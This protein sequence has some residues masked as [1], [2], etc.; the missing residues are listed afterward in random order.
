MPDTGTFSRASVGFDFQAN[1]LAVDQP[2]IESSMVSPLAFTTVPNLPSPFTDADVPWD[3]PTVLSTLKAFA[4]ANPHEVR[5]QDI[6]GIPGSTPIPGGL[7]Q[8]S[9]TLFDDG[10]R[11]IIQLQN[12]VHGPEQH[13]LRGTFAFFQQLLTSSHPL[14]IWA[15]T[16]LCFRWVAI[17]NPWG[18]ING[19]RDNA[20]GVNLNRNGRNGAAAALDPDKGAFPYSEPEAKNLKNWG[21]DDVARMRRTILGMDVHQ[22]NSPAATSGVPNIPYGFLTDSMTTSLQVQEMHRSA[23]NWINNLLAQRD[24]SGLT[25]LSPG[26]ASNQYLWERDSRL[27]PY[28]M[29]Y[30]VEKA[31]KREFDPLRT[32]PDAFCFQVEMPMGTSGNHGAM[33]TPPTAGWDQTLHGESQAVNGTVQLDLLTALVVTAQVALAPLKSGTHLAPACT[34]DQIQSPGYSFFAQSHWNGTENRP[35]SY[36]VKGTSLTVDY[37]GAP[38]DGQVVV[39]SYRGISVA[40]PTSITGAAA[41]SVA[42]GD[43]R[44]DFYCIMGGTAS[45]GGFMEFMQPAVP[46]P[47]GSSA[48][49]VYKP[50]TGNPPLP[51]LPVQTAEFALAYDASYLY[52]VCGYA[53]GAYTPNIYRIART[54]GYSLGQVYTNAVAPLLAT[55]VRIAAGAGSSASY[56]AGDT[57]FF[58]GGT[59]TYTVGAD[60]VIPSGGSALVTISPGLTVAQTGGEVV[61]LLP[62]RGTWSLWSTLATCTTG[63]QRHTAHV[64]NGA[65]YI[66]GGRDTVDYRATIIRKDLTTQAE[67]LFATVSTHAPK[68]GWHAAT[69]VGSDLY[70]AGGWGGSTARNNLTKVNLGTA[71]ITALTTIPTVVRQAKMVSDGNGSLWLATG[72]RSGDTDYTDSIYKYSIAGNSWTTYT[73]SSGWAWDSVGSDEEAA[74]ASPNL[75][76]SGANMVFNPV[77]GNILIV[78]G[79]D[80][81][82]AVLGEV[83]EFDPDVMTMYPRAASASLYGQIGKMTHFNVN[84]GQQISLVCVVSNE[85]D[86]TDLTV[87]PYFRPIWDIGP[88]G[89][90]RQAA[91]V[92]MIP[93]RAAQAFSFHADVESRNYG[94]ST[95]IRSYVRH[96]GSGTSMGFRC[97]QFTT[98]PYLGVPVDETT[99][100]AE[101]LLDVAFSEPIHSRSTQWHAFSLLPKWGSQLQANLTLAEAH[102]APGHELTALKIR[103]TSQPTILPSSTP[104]WQPG[105]VATGGFEVDYAVNGVDQPPLRLGEALE[106]NHDTS[107]TS[108]TG[109]GMPKRDEVYLRLRWDRSVVVQVW[110]YGR[111]FEVRV[112]VAD[113]YVTGLRWRGC[114]NTLTLI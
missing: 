58:D 32:L 16:H 72:R 97:Y 96:Y 25:I 101:D 29:P 52:A 41:V 62:V 77:S 113:S 94:G 11:P 61:T 55:Q 92:G 35:G 43:P 2:V 110:F 28:P 42:T 93:P 80:S 90:Y 5:Y 12:V 66:V 95:E 64:Y 69:L 1:A 48:T 71:A 46:A 78:G 33:R 51:A 31:C 37:T 3:Y 68:F 65:L 56:K 112:P 18:Y 104:A 63:L 75:F 87:S 106:I 26:G 102:V 10:V 83:Y 108:S 15:R 84:P 107:A 50:A 60:V 59:T 76:L 53:A 24:W 88:V 54:T 27:K 21:L 74:S 34:V 44:S 7:E 98:V 30:D 13:S 39:H 17:Q 103:W 114:G 91:H 100:K 38:S 20:N 109:A 70:I 47:P 105:R 57:L 73:S 22:W 9:L 79:T 19:Y 23:Y 40:W 14:M 82:S 99:G 49:S 6:A 111:L 8:P 89:S 67:T 36:S 85:S 81:N 45:A 86:A 4:Q